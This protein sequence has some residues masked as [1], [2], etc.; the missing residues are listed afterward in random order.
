MKLKQRP[1]DFRVEEL[2]RL[3]PGETGE[4]SLYRL[5]KSGIGTPE[6]L[7]VVRRD[8]RLEARAVAFAGLKD[9]HGITGQMVS[10]RRGPRTN[11]QGKGFKLNY[12]GRAERP[13]GRGTLLGNRFRIVVRDLSSEEAAR[14]AERARAAARDGFPDYYDDQRF[15]SLRGTGGKFIA[16]ALLRGDVEEALRLAIASPAHEDRS[17]TKRRRKLLRDRWGDFAGLAGS[18]DAS[19]ERR[20]CQRL[21]AGAAFDEAYRMLDRPLREIHLAAYQAHLFN[22]C[23]RRAV[24]R[25]GPRH[26]GADGPYLFYD[27]DPGPL[28]DRVFPLASAAAPADPLL[29]QVLEEEGVSRGQLAGFRPGSRHAVAIPGDLEAGEPAPDDLNPGRLCLA[30][31]FRLRPGS[32]ATMLVKR[33]T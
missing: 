5:E 19:V 1:E 31:A 13:A 7:R 9:R 22:E 29:D 28:R 2:N 27:G 3:E 33:C 12:L 24:G 15:G 23:L 25:E 4:F 6:A 32:Y 17:R 11:F 21:A 30:L 20:I 8:W 26:P 18:L 10:I 16:K 14:V